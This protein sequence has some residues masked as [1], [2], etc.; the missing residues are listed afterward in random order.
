MS[1]SLVPRA[2][3]VEALRRRSAYP[4]PAGRIEVIETHIS[5][6]LLAGDYAYKIRKPVKLPFL[7]FTSLEARLFY[8]REE[9]RLNRRTA[10]RVYLGIVPIAGEPP[11]MGGAGPVVDYA[12]KM[13]RFAQADLLSRRALEHRLDGAI[14]D[15]L[16]AGVA[17]LHRAAEVA[18]A[19]SPGESAARAAAPA[20][21]NFAQIARLERRAHPRRRLE[22]LRAW[23]E[24]RRTALAP[25]FA[26]RR[27]RGFVRECHGDLH[28]AN[29]AMVDGEPT[30]FDALEFSARLRWTDV[31]SD[32]AFV[33]MDLIHHGEPRL[34]ARFVDAYLQH[35]GD[36]EG[37]GTLRFYMVYRAMV[38]AKV[39]R[40]RGDLESFESH[41]RLAESLA[42]E[43]RAALYAMHG[44]SGSGKTWASRQMLEELGAVRIRADV[45][46]RRMHPQPSYTPE[47]TARVYRALADAARQALA[48]GF[49]VIVD[50]TCLERWQRDMLRAVAREMGVPFHLVSCEAP[51]GVLR[52]RVARRAAE[53]TDASQAG[54]SVLE[55]QL[56]RQRPLDADELGGITVLDTKGFS[57]AA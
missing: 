12:V 32:A 36:Y 25:L 55:A 47:E 26:R 24:D 43:R 31:M 28:L 56:A 49:P 9:L 16:A 5:W 22:A 46:R 34:A 45:E 42:H 27:A 23:T 10:A 7:D 54:L 19:E 21:E 11:R 37:V 13:R 51:L 14:I 30:P 1:E 20:L 53:G 44:P 4:H 57:R 39:A 38:R 29:I 2:G 50:A 41:L 17:D 40:I 15:A 8:A 35:T 6:V 48:A 3:L 18:A 52:E 33:A